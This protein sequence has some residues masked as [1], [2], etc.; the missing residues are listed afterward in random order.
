MIWNNKQDSCIQQCGLAL[1]P[2]EGSED[3]C[4]GELYNGVP[5]RVKTIRR[6]VNIKAP[7]ERGAH[8][9]YRF[10]DL[11]Y[12]FANAQNNFQR[13]QR[14]VTPQYPGAFVGWLVVEA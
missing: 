1:G 12:S 11:Q 5:N 14:R 2:L 9:L 13:K 8:M 7:E 4:L 10:G 6:S 3:A